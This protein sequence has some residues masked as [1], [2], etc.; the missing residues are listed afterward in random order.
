MHAEM[1]VILILCVFV[2]Q[3]IVM[4]WK[5]RYSKSY[6]VSELEMLSTSTLTNFNVQLVTLV[7]MWLIPL[8]I[9]LR[10]HWWRFIFI[11]LVFSCVTGLIVHKAMQRPIHGTTPR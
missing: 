2:S 9:C 10:S 8:I 1:V 3:I 6:L 7:A 11:W 5:K 4:E